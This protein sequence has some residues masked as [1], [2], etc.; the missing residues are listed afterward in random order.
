MHKILIGGWFTP[1][2]AEFAKQAIEDIERLDLPHMFKEV[3]PFAGSWEEATRMKAEMARV[4]LAAAS[5]ATLI[6]IDV[7][8]R[9]YGPRNAI[10]KLADHNA[11]IAI[12]MSGKISKS[13]G[14]TKMHPFSGTMVI[15]PTMKS[16]ELL[17]RWQAL[18]ASAPR[19]STDEATLGAAICATQGLTLSMLPETAC[20][21][22]RTNDPIIVHPCRTGRR[23]KGIIA[24]HALDRA[25]GKLGQ[26]SAAIL[27]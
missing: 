12:R 15:K 22:I 17:D 3:Q 7:D 18:G 26:I 20:A 2:Y 13:R 6:L 27:P 25:F 4:L 11:D 14:T 24:K 16:L 23:S 5:G 21:N 9:V 10:L 1:D 19:F 8:A